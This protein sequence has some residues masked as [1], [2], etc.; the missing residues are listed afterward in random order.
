MTRMLALT[1]PGLGGLL[2]DEIVGVDGLTATATGNDGRS[3][4]VL[5]DAE[6]GRQAAALGLALAEDVFAE[7]GRTLRAEGDRPDWIAGRVWRRQRAE[8]ALSVRAAAT[9]RPLPAAATF[10]V[11]ARVLQERSFLRTDLRRALTAAVGRD[12]PRW[13]V[14]DPAQVELWIAEY[15]PGRFIAGLRLSDER[16]RQHG[17]RAE[18][19]RG[20]LRPAVATA[21]VRLAGD[22]RGALLDPCCGSGT[23]LAEARA[24]GWRTI[25]RDLDPEAVRAARANVPGAAIAEGDARHLD[26]ADGSVEAA[27]TNLPFGRQFQVAGSVDDWLREVTAELTRVTRPGGQVVLLA[28]EVPAR[29]LPAGLRPAGGRVRLRLLGTPTSIWTYRRE[30]RRGRMPS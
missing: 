13:R 12:R 1:V 7:V 24:R 28:P 18:Q 21:M 5:L 25:G 3:D 17:G 30:G 16:M 22:P 20:A 19:R 11:V 14:A 26:L 15:Q 2:R 9:G 23:I 29:V 6:R 27:V 8:R 10:R 4:V